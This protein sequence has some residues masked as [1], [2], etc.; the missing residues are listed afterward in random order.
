MGD[1]DGHRHPDGSRPGGLGAR[2]TPTGPR[3]AT[4]TPQPWVVHR[5]GHTVGDEVTVAEEVHT[6][7]SEC[8]LAG[9]EITGIDG[10]AAHRPLPCT[11][12]LTG[13]H[14][15]LLSVTN[16]VT[17]AP[18]DGDHRGGH[19]DGYNGSGGKRGS[20]GGGR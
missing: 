14:Q 15:H 9:S 12:G 13:P 2:L 7:G 10:A 8:T 20:G 1:V 11:T 18:P 16:T 19:G 4:A 17:C 5:P 3:S 6:A